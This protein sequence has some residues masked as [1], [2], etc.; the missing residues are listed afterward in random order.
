MTVTDGLTYSQ[1]HPRGSPCRQGERSCVIAVCVCVCVC[2]CVSAGAAVLLS[3]EAR[4]SCSTGS[5]QKDGGM[6]EEGGGRVDGSICIC[7]QGESVCTSSC[8][9]ADLL[10]LFLPRVLY[11]PPR[12]FPFISFSRYFSLVPSARRSVRLYNHNLICLGSYYNE[13]SAAEQRERYRALRF[14]RC[15]PTTKKIISRKTQLRFVELANMSRL[16]G[17]DNG[18]CIDQSRQ[19]RGE[20]SLWSRSSPKKLIFIYC[21]RRPKQMES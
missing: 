20:N 15:F 14:K 16:E 19:K 11:L 1:W 6:Q 2:A 13:Q 4:G 17:K 10:E 5:V 7:V 21:I 8:C 12:L 18:N 3:T 9:S